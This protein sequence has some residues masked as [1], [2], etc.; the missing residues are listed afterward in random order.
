[1][2]AG[3]RVT[4]DIDIRTLELHLGSMI[5]KEQNGAVHA[6][7]FGTSL[8]V[9]T[10]VQTSSLLIAGTE[11]NPNEYATHAEVTTDVAEALVDYR[12][13]YHL[14]ETAD[15]VVANHRMEVPSLNIEEVELTTDADGHLNVA[16]TLD[17]QALQID[18]VV[19]DMV[20]H[21]TTLDEHGE[22]FEGVEMVGDPGDP[23]TKVYVW[24]VDHE[25]RSL[26]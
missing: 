16:A 23:D 1:L 17:V 6:S 2:A 9:A 20:G 26:D 13:F 11:F 3:V 25:L 4:A 14:S 24:D 7:A 8:L 12:E 19:F 18:G 5:M 21:N 10:S 15:A 22:F